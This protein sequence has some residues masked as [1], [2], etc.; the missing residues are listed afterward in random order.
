[1]SILDRLLNLRVFSR[2]MHLD[3]RA[4]EVLEEQK[5]VR[6]DLNT[7]LERV[8]RATLN[9]ETDWFLRLVKKDPE[10]AINIVKECELKNDN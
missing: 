3:K 8:T 4:E 10:C 1:M 6:E 9:G 2:I 5:E 7:R